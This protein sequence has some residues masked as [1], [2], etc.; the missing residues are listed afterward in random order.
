MNYEDLTKADQK[1]ART[2]NNSIRRVR[3]FRSSFRTLP[4][5]GVIGLIEADGEEIYRFAAV[6]IKD[7]MKHGG[8]LIEAGKLLKVAYE[9]RDLIRRIDA[10]R[11]KAFKAMK[12]QRRR[13][14]NGQYALGEK[15]AAVLAEAVQ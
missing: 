2:I 6:S 8:R 9:V 10:P 11:F 15:F 12:A 5:G 4:N 13:A 3:R 14:R 7:A 1:A